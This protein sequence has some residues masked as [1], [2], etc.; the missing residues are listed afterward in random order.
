M[1]RVLKKIVI[2][3]LVAGIIIGNG[4]PQLLQNE[5]VKAATV[6]EKNVKRVV[7]LLQDA[8]YYQIQYEMSPNQIRKFNFSKESTCM[9]FFKSGT[10]SSTDEFSKNVFGRK[11]KGAELTIGD[12]GYEWPIIKI[13]KIKKKDE[14]IIASYKVYRS[15]D[16]IY[17]KEEVVATG[18]ACLKNSK[19]SKYKYAITNLSIKRNG[20]R[21][22]GEE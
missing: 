6:N 18:N 7:N 22:T 17:P 19:V 12:W 1:K 11:I 9:K 4:I 16:D 20:Y 10:E 2:I 3:I 15:D 21:V 8:I 5:E 13:S 14:K